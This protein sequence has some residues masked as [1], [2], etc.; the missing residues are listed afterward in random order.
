MSRAARP[1]GPA[2]LDP[3]RRREL[4]KAL[5]A[6]QHLMDEVVP[7]SQY[8]QGRRE[9]VERTAYLGNIVERAAARQ[10]E[11]DRAAPS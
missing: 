5:A 7:E 10:R 11:R 9:N 8:F 6:Y 2:D 3:E 1:G 4:A